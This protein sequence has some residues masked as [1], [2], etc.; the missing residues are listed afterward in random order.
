M[1][2]CIELIIKNALKNPANP[3]IIEPNKQTSY[4]EFLTEV[5]V[6]ATYFKK[7]ECH[8][9][10][11]NMN[12]GKDAYAIIVATLM[13]GGYFCPLNQ[14]SPEERKLYVIKESNPDII[15]TQQNLMISTSKVGK[16][17]QITVS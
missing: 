9:I 15:L 12:Q 6:L 14:D 13:I 10:L 5:L 11:I 4:Q 2:D 7:H 3:C 16:A 1:N 8:T 17:K